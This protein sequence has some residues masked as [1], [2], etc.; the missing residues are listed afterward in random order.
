MSCSVYIFFGKKLLF[1]NFY[2]N[3]IFFKENKNNLEKAYFFIKWG[4]A[5][6]M[7]VFSPMFLMNNNWGGIFVSAILQL[8]SQYSSTNS[9]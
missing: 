8:C 4:L 7:R 3:S 5:H 1:L 9:L 6:A 2:G